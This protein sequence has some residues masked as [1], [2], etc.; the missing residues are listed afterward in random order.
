MIMVIIQRIQRI[1]TPREIVAGANRIR[2]NYSSG[3]VDRPG[4]WFKG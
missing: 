1:F 4:V 3:N 2:G